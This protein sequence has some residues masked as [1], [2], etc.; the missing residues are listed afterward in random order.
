M[1]LRTENNSAC[2]KRAGNHLS[3]DGLTSPVSGQQRLS[4]QIQQ[5]TLTTSTSLRAPL[6]S[7]N[8]G[9]DR[10]HTGWKLVNREGT[11]LD[12]Q[13]VQQ[14]Q[15]GQREA[16]TTLVSKWQDRIYTFCLRQLGER[17]LAE[18]ATQDI[19]V[20]VFTS[21]QSFRMESKFSTWLYRISTN[22]CIN[23]RSKHHRRHRK[24]HHSFDEMD[25]Q[26]HTIDNPIDR[27]ETL[28]FE[29]QL[30]EALGQIPEEHRALLILRDIQDCSYEEIADITN[31]NL[32]TIKSRI[33]RGRKQLKAV[34]EGDR[35]E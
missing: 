19:F 20:K 6:D 1:P 15:H 30:Q 29:Q 14:L 31:L 17:E 8:N 2:L 28:D 21:I 16:F 33:H 25:N 7:D 4:T 34:L 5:D 3:S 22:H 10:L 26:L 24:Q 11:M 35:N 13:L 27:L 23:L 9:T 12:E 18:E 32:G